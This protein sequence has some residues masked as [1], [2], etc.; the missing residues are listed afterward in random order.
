VK[1]D[2]GQHRFQLSAERH[3][4]K[5]VILAPNANCRNSKLRQRLP[6]RRTK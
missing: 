2:V 4:G 6:V 1:L 5:A 3:R